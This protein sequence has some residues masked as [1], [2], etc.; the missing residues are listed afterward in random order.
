LNKQGI[1]S[2]AAEIDPEDIVLSSKLGDGCFG[3]VYRGVC[4]AK[5][6]AVKIPL[7]QELDEE[8]LQLLRTEIELMSANP[9]PNIVLFMGACTIPKNFKIVTE[10]MNG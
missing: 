10:L 6:V 3:A 8:Q 4:R 9:H 2:T 1:R 7:V 5:E